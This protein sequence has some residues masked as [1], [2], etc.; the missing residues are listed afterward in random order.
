MP[1]NIHETDEI[2]NMIKDYLDHYTSDIESVHS[3]DWSQNPS[4]ADIWYNPGGW[5]IV[6]PAG[7]WWISYYLN[8]YQTTS[9]ASIVATLS[10]ANNSESAK[11]HSAFGYGGGGSPYL[12][13]SKR[14]K[15][16]L[17]SETTYYLNVKSNFN[18]V[19]YVN[20]TTNGHGIITAEKII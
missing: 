10:T 4:V 7:D 5:N 2:R 9:P 13:M 6:I 12:P 16:S 11:K 1:K 19:L 14:F 15:L 17:A 20:S 3:S 18:G 8:L